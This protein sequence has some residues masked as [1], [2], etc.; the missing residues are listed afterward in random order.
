MTLAGHGGHFW[1]QLATVP[2]G[3]TPA[4]STPPVFAGIETNSPVDRCHEI[5]KTNSLDKPCP[6]IPQT[7][8]LDKSCGKIVQTKGLTK[9]CREIVWTIIV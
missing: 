1:Q 6:Q 5:A 7:R 3:V 4:P 8:S 2:D 9:S